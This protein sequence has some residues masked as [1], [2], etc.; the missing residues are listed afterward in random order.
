MNEHVKKTILDTLNKRKDRL[1]HKGTHSIE[2]SQRLLR[3]YEK[4]LESGQ[5]ETHHTAG[6]INVAVEVVPE[7]HKN[8]IKDLKNGIKK[9][10]SIVE[11]LTEAITYVE[12]L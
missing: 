1:T 12:S 8:I 3:M 4:E 9:R 11:D 5:S 10:Q 6:S 2:N 7:T